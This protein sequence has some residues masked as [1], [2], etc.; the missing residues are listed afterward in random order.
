M[1]KIVL[2]LMLN[3]PFIASQI[4][5]NYI[6]D[7]YQE[8]HQ[9][10]KKMKK[11]KNFENIKALLR[12]EYVDFKEVQKELT[13]LIKHNKKAKIFSKDEIEKI[14]DIIEKM[15]VYKPAPVA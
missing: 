1:K 9:L 8:S 12:G 10:I 6:L 14:K 3:I 15:Q 5:S 11:L 2:I 4:Q 7:I 13:N